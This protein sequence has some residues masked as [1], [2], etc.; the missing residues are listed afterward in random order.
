MNNS[1]LSNSINSGI[2]LNYNHYQ[3]PQTYDELTI[4]N[5][6]YPNVQHGNGLSNE[7]RISSLEC[8]IETLEK[9]VK[10]YDNL[11]HLK[12]EERKNEFNITCNETMS[13]FNSRIEQI[14]KKI[15][16]LHLNQEQIYQELMSKIDFIE[17]SLQSESRAEK[18]K[19]NENDNKSDLTKLDSLM[20]KNELLVN[21]LVDDKISMLNS[22]NEKRINDIL[23]IIQD[24]NKISDEN[25]YEINELKESVRNIQTENVDVIKVVSVHTEKT[26][27][28]DF[29]VEQIS[30]LKE[31][32]TKL[33][34]IFGDNQKEEEDFLQNYLIAGNQQTINQNTFNNNNS[35]I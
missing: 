5:D 2:N 4:S 16:Q 22:Q 25:E 35:T 28:I 19:Q 10:F 20:Y 18:E 6:G 23:T 1:H 32:F 3:R 26:K 12:H 24:L 7:L 21:N 11:I 31:K 8:R 13:V 14:E 30:E 17:K 33:M 9:M 15:E 27:Q 29:I 34:I